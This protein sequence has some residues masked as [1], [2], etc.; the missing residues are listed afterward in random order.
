MRMVGTIAV[1]I[2][3]LLASPAWAELPVV[4]EARVSW[5]GCDY[6]I[7]VRKRAYPPDDP[8]PW[9]YYYNI[10]VQS[11]VVS[12]GSCSLTPRTVE[13]ATSESEPRIAIVANAEGLVVA[14]S[15]G[16]YVRGLGD[17]YRIRIHRLDPSTLGSVRVAVLGASFLPEDVGAGDP[18]AVNL[19]ELTLHPGY[20]EV[21]G[22]FYG[23]WIMDETETIPWPHPLL[24]GD[25]FVAIYPDFFGSTQRPPHLVTF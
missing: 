25:R 8:Y 24:Q 21:N 12:L 11:E 7:K 17:W 3:A 19:Q 4:N 2:V 23:N 14:Y 18:G 20:L 5:Q 13:L 22:S 16:D 6:S 9:F 1:G 10:S 15:F